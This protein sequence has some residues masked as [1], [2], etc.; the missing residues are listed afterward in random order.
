MST[1]NALG[2][3]HRDI[4]P[5]NVLVTP[6]GPIALSSFHYATFHDNV[7]DKL[8]E[9]FPAT[10]FLAPEMVSARRTKYGY[11]AT[12]DVWAFGMVVLDMITGQ[13]NASEVSS[14]A[15]ERYNLMMPFVVHNLIDAFV[16]DEL[17]SDLLHA[18]LQEDPLR[19]PSW[20]TIRDHAFFSA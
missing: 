11:D 20:D 16:D 1:L 4:R 6:E 14:D 7:S 2:I 9:S 8:I 10:G 15:L 19:R 17:A 3:V 18:I 5:D 13:V 12:S